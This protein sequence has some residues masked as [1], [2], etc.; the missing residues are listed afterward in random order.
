MKPTVPDRNSVFDLRSSAIPRPGESLDLI[1]HAV[2]FWN[3]FRSSPGSR[4]KAKSAPG[5]STTPG[6]LGNVR[7][8]QTVVGGIYLGRT[9]AYCLRGPGPLS[10]RPPAVWIGPGPWSEFTVPATRPIDWILPNPLSARPRPHCQRG[11]GP[12]SSEILSFL[13][14]RVAP[15]RGSRQLSILVPFPHLPGSNPKQP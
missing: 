7:D 11:P 4:R 5:P 3:C 6:L 15:R 12:L 10:D 13:W 14:G 8:L 1:W 2:S 9:P